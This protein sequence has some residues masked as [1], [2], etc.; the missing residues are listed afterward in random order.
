MLFGHG[1]NHSHGPHGQ[2]L[3]EDDDESGSDSDSD[4]EDE[5]ES[6]KCIELNENQLNNLKEN[7][8]QTDS[9]TADQNPLV[10]SAANNDESE[11]NKVKK[12]TRSNSPSKK[13][14]CHILCMQN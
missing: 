1:H 3:N 11:P 12:R 14:R 7:S 8:K 2:D 6:I 4:G 5:L 10:K 13:A 9:A